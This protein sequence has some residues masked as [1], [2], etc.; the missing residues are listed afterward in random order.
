MVVSQ[1]PRLLLE[2]D[3]DVQTA[4]AFF[5]K[6]P[7]DTREGVQRAFDDAVMQC[8]TCLLPEM[9]VNGRRA[10]VCNGIA[11]NGK[12][13][14]MD[15]RVHGES[16]LKVFLRV[17]CQVRVMA[18][19]SVLAASAGGRGAKG[20]ANWTMRRAAAFSMAC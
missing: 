6:A 19:T 15:V 12:F 7:D 20:A 17:K 2:R 16:V 1:L 3:G 11:Y 8:D 9:M 13:F 14:E 18:S 10:T 4:P 5:K